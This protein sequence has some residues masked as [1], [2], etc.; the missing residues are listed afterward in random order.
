MALRLTYTNACL[1]L[2]FQVDVTSPR[3]VHIAGPHSFQ[4]SILALVQDT[5]NQPESVDSNRLRL[6]SEDGSEGVLLGT[7]CRDCRVLVFGPQTFCQSCTSADLEPVELSPR[8]TLYSYTVV[9]VPSAGWPG[10]VPYVL[11]QIELRE[12]PHVL[13]EVVD[14]LEPDLR[15]GM[16]MELVLRNVRPDE[17]EADIAVYKWRPYPSQ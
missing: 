12:G 4:P 16:D 10:P 3:Q 15:I 14:C 9:R 17:S 2:D 1:N 6:T 7:R 13:A 8:G 11:G 5:E